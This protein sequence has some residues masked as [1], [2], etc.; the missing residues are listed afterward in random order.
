MIRLKLSNSGATEGVK[1]HLPATPAEVAEA[2][3]WFERIGIEPSAVRITGVNSSVSNLG[4][5]ILRAD[6]YDAGQMKMLNEL[7]ASIEQMTDREQDIFAGA[8]DAESINSLGDVLE[9][10]KYLNDYVILPNIGTDTELG[11]FLGG[12]R[13]QELP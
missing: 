4:P 13:L 9:L 11:R 8:L 1:L 5:Y 10:S 2:Y 12:Y 6:I 7:A 3:S